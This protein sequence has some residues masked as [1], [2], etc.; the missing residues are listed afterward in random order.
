MHTTAITNRIEMAILVTDNKIAVATKTTTLLGE[1]TSTEVTMVISRE[2]SSSRTDL[3][4]QEISRISR[5]PTNMGQK[6][7]ETQADLLSEHLREI[8]K[9]QSKM[10]KHANSVDGDQSTI[11]QYAPQ[12]K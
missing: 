12:E 3:T 4:V 6:P 8:G 10:A 7:R 2:I 9:H 5:D 11:E 1:E